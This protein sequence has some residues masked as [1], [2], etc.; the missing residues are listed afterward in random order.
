MQQWLLNYEPP[1]AGQSVLFVYSDWRVELKTNL[2]LF[3]LLAIE[4]FFFRNVQA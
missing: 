2:V 1:V 4:M 3:L